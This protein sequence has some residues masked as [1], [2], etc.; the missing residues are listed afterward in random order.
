MSSKT[1]LDQ[2]F[3]EKIEKVRYLHRLNVL[4]PGSRKVAKE[5]EQLT[6]VSLGVAASEEESAPKGKKGKKGK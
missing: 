5:I 4:D 3:T 2:Q 6:G 1:F